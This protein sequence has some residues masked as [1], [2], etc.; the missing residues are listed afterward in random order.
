M[1]SEAIVSGDMQ[2][3]AI[4]SGDMQAEAIVSGDMQAEAIVSG[5]S[6]LRLLFLVTAVS[7]YCFLGHAACLRHVITPQMIQEH[8]IL[9][10]IEHSIRSDSDIS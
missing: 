1:Q 9:S 7:G 6:S 4:V 10:P 2:P 3:E 5:D 8:A